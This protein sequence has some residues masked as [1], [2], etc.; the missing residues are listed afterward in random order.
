MRVVMT[1]KRGPLDGEYAFTE[2]VYSLSLGSPL[3][4]VNVAAA[5]TL[6]KLMQGKE[7]GA[8]VMSFSPAGQERIRRGSEGLE[9]WNTKYRLISREVDDNTRII[10]CEHVPP[11]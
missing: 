7:V 8:E 1:I 11:N 5:K 10:V 4:D 9:N 3:D 6:Y 2:S